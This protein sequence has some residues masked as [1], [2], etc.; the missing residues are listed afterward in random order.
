MGV[1]ERVLGE[2]LAHFVD[3]VGDR[4]AVAVEGGRTKWHE[5][6]PLAAGTRTVRAPAGVVAYEPAEMTVRAGAGTTLRELDATLRPSGQTTVLDGPPHATIGGVLATNANGIRRL[7]VGPVRD[8][9]L[10]ARYVSADGRLITAGGPTVK[11]VTGYDLCRLLVGSLGTLGL[12]GEVVLRTRPRPRSSQW[13]AGTVDPD[14]V[15]NALYRPG[16]VLWDGTSTWV[17]LEGYEQDVD[18]QAAIA[19]ELG[20]GPVDGP[21]VL[22]PHRWSLTPA[23]VRAHAGAGDAFVAEMG[24]GVVHSSRPA[25]PRDVSPEVRALHERIKHE[26]DPSGRCN[27]GRDPLHVATEVVA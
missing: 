10:E 15:G 26:F 1:T 20:M 25:P 6:G 12:I 7:R 17:L 27:P 22:P 4:G 14:L 23:A 19:R 24:V 16:C 11:N 21:P 9:L 13:L 18:A 5:G 2:A 8:A 3:Q